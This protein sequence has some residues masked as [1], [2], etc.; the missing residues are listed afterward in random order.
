MDVAIVFS[1]LNAA[2]LLVLLYFY[3]KIAVRSHAAHSIG[4]AFFAVLLLATSVLTAYS[5][6]AMSPFFG[7]AALPYLSAIAIVEFLGLAVLVRITL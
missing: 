5:Y 2:M 4:M 7:D 1:G 6:A 3:A